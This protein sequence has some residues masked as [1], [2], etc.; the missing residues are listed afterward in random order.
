MKK[1]LILF[2]AILFCPE[3]VFGHLGCLYIEGCSYTSDFNDTEIA[4]IQHKY[5]AILHIVEIL[6][7]CLSKEGCLVVEKESDKYISL[8][9]GY[10]EDFVMKRAKIH[11]F[12]WEEY[13]PNV[14]F[15]CIIQVKIDYEDLIEYIETER[16]WG[17]QTKVC[18]NHKRFCEIVE[19]IP[20]I[21]AVDLKSRS[22]IEYE[23][24]RF[25]EAFRKE[26]E[27]Q[28]A[29]KQEDEN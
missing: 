6:E 15:R 2:C 4:K 8:G 29:L 3:L 16:Y 27:K 1:Y 9:Y 26:F 11:K 25:R 18:L 5:N 7:D 14:M 22:S 21:E 10:L 28:K 12:T 17:S 23:E 24:S 13:R 19:A 20:E